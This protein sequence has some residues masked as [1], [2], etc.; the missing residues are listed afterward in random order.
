MVV[1]RTPGGEFA[2]LE[3]HAPLLAQLRE[4][5]V[6]IKGADGETGFLCGSGTLEVRDGEVTVLTTDV[7]PVDDID[8]DA[9]R[10]RSEDAQATPEARA[11]ATVRLRTAERMRGQ[12]A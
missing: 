3:G 7:E 12:H 5:P 11:A 6:R 4:G 10:R 1:A 8:L 2:V 9:L